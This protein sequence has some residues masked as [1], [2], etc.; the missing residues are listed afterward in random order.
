MWAAPSARP[1]HSA[2]ASFKRAADVLD[3]EV[4]D[5]RRP[6]RGRRRGARVVVVAAPR[7]AERHR[8][9]RVVVDQP[10]QDQTAGGVD[11]LVALQAA[12]DGDDRLSVDQDV[13]V[14][15]V[16]GGDDPPTADE[17]CHRPKRTD[18][19]AG[20]SSAAL[21]AGPPADSCPC[22][23]AASGVEHR[24]GERR[25]APTPASRALRRCSRRATRPRSTSR[26]DRRRRRL[27]CVRPRRERTTDQRVPGAARTTVCASQTRSDTRPVRVA[28][29]AATRRRL[30]GPA[31]LR[32]PS[33]PAGSTPPTSTTSASSAPGA[34]FYDAGS[35]ATMWARSR[36]AAGRST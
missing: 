4:D 32:R 33:A 34:D 36:V 1:C 27:R 8:E 30:R 18:A 10:R 31:R 16:G 17:P 24:I 11:L 29:P 15:R 14:E 35:P 20:T 23:S 28:T 6:A 12:A 22:A 2:S 21:S 26:L 9:V 5:A 19:S 7:A 3:A 13:G 25:V